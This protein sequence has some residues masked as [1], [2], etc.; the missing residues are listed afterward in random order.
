[1]RSAPALLRYRTAA[2]LILSLVPAAARAQDVDAPPD[3]VHIDVTSTTLGGWHTGNDGYGE[4]FERL[5]VGSGYERWQMGLRLDTATFASRTPSTAV[6]NRYTLEKVS[7]G[8]T[9]RVVEVSAGD[10]YVSFGRGLAL[11][12][13]KV[14][15][16]GVDT[17]LRGGKLL[18]HGDRI[19]GTL[20]V[21]YT[22]INNV[23]EATGKSIDDP[24]DLI[25]GVQLQGTAGAVTMGAHAAAFA[26]HDSLGLVA[27]RAYRDRYLQFGPTFD[28]P[29]LTSW[30]GLYL[31]GVGQVRQTQADHGSALGVYGSATVYA[32]RATILFEGKGYGDLEPV[33][34]H[35]SQPEF[36]TIAYNNPPTVERLLQVIENPQKNIAGGRMRCDWSFSPALLVYLNYGFF[37]DWQGY[38]DPSAVGSNRAA[39]IHDPYVGMEARAVD[40]RSWL[41]V[42]GGWRSVLLDGNGDMVRS[43]VHAEVDAARAL[44][45]TWSATL[46]TLVEKRRKYESP[47]LD[48]YFSEGTLLAGLRFGRWGGLAGGYDFTTDPTQ[49]KRDYFN[50][51]LEWNITSSSSLRLFAGGTRG[52]LRC[53]SGVC[54]VFPPF[55]GVRLSATVRL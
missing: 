55:E 13:R 32:G 52:G 49:P 37:R 42:S 51:N 47:I 36:E 17:T 4:L 45:A 41:L 7:L 50:A 27:D 43:D 21:G 5:N 6:E 8:W 20:A 44:G 2:A 18:V 19:G 39:D 11:S 35:V 3:A 38:A 54:R 46:H 34:P 48:R 26:F 14:D 16:L 10:A 23:D 22:N 12:L 30:L 29:R 28:A 9:S 53:V 40:G 33:K 1:M 25:A 24:R 15:E 31:E